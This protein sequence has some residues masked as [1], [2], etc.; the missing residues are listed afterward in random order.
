MI[1]EELKQYR[2]EVQSM[3]YAESKKI[4]ERS[5]AVDINK[6]HY[7]T[8][9]KQIKDLKTEYDTYIQEREIDI[10]KQKELNRIAKTM[11]GQLEIKLASKTCELEKQSNVISE[12]RNELITK[13]KI[14]ENYSA[15]T[16]VIE[17]EKN[18]E[19]M[20]DNYEAK[21]KERD[22]IIEKEREINLLTDTKLLLKTQN[23]LALEAE[24]EELKRYKEQIPTEMILYQESMKKSFKEM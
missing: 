11:E 24:N 15:K 9:Q 7:N 3:K 20:K 19:N 1:K 4:K 8:L 18:Q 13:G 5:C 16:M 22:G 10:E 17:Y 23:A 2:T 21:L 6:A 12:L 14:I